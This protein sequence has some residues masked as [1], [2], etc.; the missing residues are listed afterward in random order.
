M[1][2]TLSRGSRSEGTESADKE[3]KIS[4][5]KSGVDENL[6][7][8]ENNPNMPSCTRVMKQS[9]VTHTSPSYSPSEWMN[10][11]IDMRNKCTSSWVCAVVQPHKWTKWHQKSRRKITF[12]KQMKRQRYIN[13]TQQMSHLEVLTCDGACIG[14]HHFSEVFKK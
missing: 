10:S 5:R 1:R 7:S 9:A 8:P 4:A 14:S 2:L 12:D 13:A 6:D 11:N 3:I